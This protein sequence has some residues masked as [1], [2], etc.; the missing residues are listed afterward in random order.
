MVENI[1]EIAMEIIIHA[2]NAKAEAYDA[3]GC[4]KKNDNNKV[5]GLLKS[6]EEELV[7]SHKTHLKLLGLHNN[8]KCINE[9]LLVNHAMDTMMTTM[10]EINLIKELIELYQR[11]ER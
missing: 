8:F 4:A 1:E 5:E 9:Q 2:A 11:K 6:A 3:L 10:S 7:E